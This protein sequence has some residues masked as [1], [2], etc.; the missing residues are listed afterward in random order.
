LN[1]TGDG[2]DAE[3]RRNAWWFALEAPFSQLPFAVGGFYALFAIQMG[4]SN[5]V[6][7][8]LTSGPALVNLL[9]LIPAGAVVQASKNYARPFAYGALLQRV[10]LMALALIPFLPAEWRAWSLVGMVMVTSVPYAVRNLAFQATAGEM[11]SPRTFNRY[12]GL[13]WTIMSLT[14]VATMPLLG[15]LMDLIRFPLNFQLLFGLTG[16]VT[17]LA[18]GLILKLRVPTH[19]KPAARSGHAGEPATRPAFWATYGGFVLFEIGVAVSYLAFS[20]AAPVSRIYWVRD[21]LANG[22]WVGAL[23]A[24]ASVGSMVGTLMWGRLNVGR[25]LR[26]VV[27]GLAAVYFGLNPLLTAAMGSLAPLV[28]L[29]VAVGLASGCA[30]LAIFDRL[31]RVSS[32]ERRPLFL[33]IH[34]VVINGS[35]FVGPLISTHLADTWG[36]RP[37]LAAMGAVGVA[38]AALIYLLGWGKGPDE[39]SRVEPAG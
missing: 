6:V 7:G 12:V 16:L 14:D 3:E 28:V 29:G 21:L 37:A 34:S 5:A 18:V 39:A 2:I 20:A 23:T 31:M 36:A 27:L 32:R 4:A 33:S 15:R 10:L 25:R 17:L 35:A 38:G 13:R 9:W 11:F 19:P 26:V 22:A 1:P 8:W 30:E 24:A